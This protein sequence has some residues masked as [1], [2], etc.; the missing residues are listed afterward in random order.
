MIKRIGSAARRDLE[1]FL[2]TRVYL[3]LHVKV[4]ERWRENRRLLTELGIG[5]KD[6]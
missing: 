2:G 4:R 3:G 6:P 5:P 1:Q